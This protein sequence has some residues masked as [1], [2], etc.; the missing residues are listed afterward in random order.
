MDALH[1][2][3][4]WVIFSFVLFLGIAWKFGRKPIAASLDAKIAVI[5]AEIDTAERL[6]DEAKALLL[7]YEARQKEI[8]TMADKMVSDAR[9]QA[10][11][12][13][14]REEA[15]MNDLMKQ[16]EAQLTERLNLMRDQAID[17]IRQVAA[18]LAYDATRKMVGQKLDDETR[19]KLVERALD[20]VSQQLN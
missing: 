8:E 1:D 5:R 9:D 7:D 20:H 18:T 11:V 4:T 6:R 3:Y 17:D 10:E 16:K 15:R 12:L 14:Q 19:N 2:P 13:R